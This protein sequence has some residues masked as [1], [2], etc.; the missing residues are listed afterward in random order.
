MAMIPDMGVSMPACY[1]QFGKLLN[2][3]DAVASC[4]WHCDGGDH[5]VQYLIGRCVSNA[6]ASHS[7]LMIG[8]Y[9]ESLA[10]TRSIGELANLLLLFGYDRAAFAQ[11]RAA[12]RKERLRLFQPRHVRDELEKRQIPVGID[13]ERYAALSEI[14]VHATPETKPNAHNPGRKANLGGRQQLLGAMIC[15]NELAYSLGLAGA[16]AGSTLVSDPRGKAELRSESVALI[17]SIGGATILNRDELLTEL[18]DV[19]VES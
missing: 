13:R 8:M 2:V 4:R 15:M 12:D 18:E 14:G 9:D 19:S 3:L 16:A 6:R 11:W 17:R 1:A 10:L 5:L 7:L